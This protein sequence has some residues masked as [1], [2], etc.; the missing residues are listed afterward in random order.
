MDEGAVLGRPSIG[1]NCVGSGITCSL[2]GGTVTMTVGGSSGSATW[3]LITGTLSAQTDLQNAL[4]AKAPANAEYWVNTASAGLSAE[5]VLGT[6]AGTIDGLCIGQAGCTPVADTVS[7]GDAT[8]FLNWNGGTTPQLVFD[9]NDVLQYRRSTDTLTMVIGSTTEFALST[10]GVIITEG[11]QVGF[12][13]GTPTTD[14][15]QV[16]DANFAFG[17]LTAGT[18]Y[19]IRFD[20]GG[21]TYSYNRTTNAHIWQIAG[22]NEMLLNASG[23]QLQDPLAVVYGGTGLGGLSQGDTLYA[24]A[25]NTL[26]A[27]AK[28]TNA[29][30]YYSNTGSSNNPAWAQVNLANGVTGNLPVGNLN[31]GSGASS[32]TFWRGDGTWA[33]AGGPTLIHTNST[34]GTG[35]GSFTDTLMTWSI[36]INTN[37]T[38]SCEGPYHTTG[39]T[40]S[41]VLG[42]NGPA[43]GSVTVETW[44]ATSATAASYA[45]AIAYNAGTDPGAGPGATSMPF[46]ITGFVGNTNSGTVAIRFH[47]GGAGGGTTTID[48]GAVC[49]VHLN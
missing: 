17:V 12:S 33:A 14:E 15:V 37:S 48:V 13:G 22:N 20:T 2:T 26:S 6:A 7:V 40:D 49:V 45:R 32:A 34:S 27:L 18:T 28:D 10:T 9:T 8:F 5:K 3:G 46:R 35:S 30:R 38:F 44:I 43:G 4:D 29:T 47:H 21:D 25:S 16:G 39:T 23:L 1:I 11:L 42:V 24:S 19:G 36:P 41:L 31:S